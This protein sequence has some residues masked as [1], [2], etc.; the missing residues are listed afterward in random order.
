MTVRQTRQKLK[1]LLF[2][3]CV[4][5]TGEDFIAFLEQ[6]GTIHN[7][8]CEYTPLQNDLAER[9]N[10]TLLEMDSSMLSKKTTEISHSAG[11]LSSQLHT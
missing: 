6:N 1:T 4:E 2:D 11:M 3:G 7:K 8:A 5:Y 9:T 10:R